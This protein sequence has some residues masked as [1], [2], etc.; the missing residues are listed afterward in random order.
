MNLFCAARSIVQSLA[1][2]TRGQDT[3]RNKTKFRKTPLCDAS[4]ESLLFLYSISFVTWDVSFIC[5]VCGCLCFGCA[6]AWSRGAAPLRFLISGTAWA[7]ACPD[8]TSSARHASPLFRCSL[9][10]NVAIPS[11][12]NALK[13]AILY[14]PW[15]SSYSRILFEKLFKAIP[16]I[17]LF[18][19]C[20]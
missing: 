17:W 20:T 6:C 16:D 11:T 18:Q 14:L 7:H 13:M 1:L 10:A 2:L 8:L 3:S 9:V 5:L 4:A 15:V 19:R 12:W